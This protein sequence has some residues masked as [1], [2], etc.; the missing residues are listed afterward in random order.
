[1]TQ[2]DNDVIRVT[3]IFGYAGSPDRYV[4]VWH[5]QLDTAA[6]IPDVDMITYLGNW[7]ENVYAEILDIQVAGYDYIEWD[8]ANVTQDLVYPAEPWPTY[9]NGIVVGDVLPPNL[10]AYGFGRTQF[11]K[12]YARKYFNGMA[13]SHN[14]AGGAADAAV[15]A[16]LATALA[17]GWG[18]TVIGAGIIFRGGLVTT[19]HGFVEPSTIIVPN[20]W[21]ALR[22]RI[23]G[24]GG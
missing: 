18:D 4:N 1:M 21:R 13:E 9:T 5:I 20:T 11:S 3:P 6:D 22:R 19:L 12:V 16:A 17:A 15:I 14:T 8:W 24:V 23:L 7:L 2:H 10:S